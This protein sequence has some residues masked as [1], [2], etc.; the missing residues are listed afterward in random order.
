MP[1]PIYFD[2]NATTQL[3]PDVVDIV[4]RTM[5]THF[6]NPFTQYSVG[7]KA[8]EEMEKSRKN[9]K[10]MLGVQK[11]ETLIFTS[12]ATESN[13]LVIRGRVAH[14]SHWMK[15]PHIIMTSIEHSSVYQTC[16]DLQKDGRCSLSIVPTDFHGRIIQKKLQQE[17]QK[18]AN[19]L[20]MI[21]II[22]ANNE[23]GVIQD[24]PI[25]SKICRGHFLH[26]DAT[27]YIGKYPIRISSLQISSLTFGGHKF[28]GPRIGAL[29]L[30]NIHDVKNQTCSGGRSEYGLRS[31]TPNLPYIL[32]LEKA[33]SINLKDAH[34]NHKKVGR[35]RD[36]LEHGLKQQI[37]NI[38]INSGS[39]DRLYNTLSVVLPI[40]GQSKKLVRFLDKHNICVNVGSACDRSTRSRILEAMGLTATERG[41]TLRLSLSPL[42]TEHECR[43]FLSI[44]EQYFQN[45]KKTTTAT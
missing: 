43:V 8:Q 40:H 4:C 1:S 19:H 24:L 45:K 9:I 23:T 14:M 7:K 12:C 41:S 6:A 37:P 13:N 27:Q 38:R 28:N 39:V 34:R 15:M 22:L 42:N 18:H 5:K 32:G 30:K 10:K 25:I 29:Y 44:L 17:I 21:C 33:L 3:H 16:K 20:S 11:K 35:L 26:V 31:G 2:N 36:L